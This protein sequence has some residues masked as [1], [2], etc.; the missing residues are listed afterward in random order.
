MF[1]LSSLLTPSKVRLGPEIAAVPDTA[2]AALPCSAPSPVKGIPAEPPSSVSG[3]TSFMIPQ[4]SVLGARPDRAGRLRTG[5]ETSNATALVIFGAGALK[6]CLAEA[7]V[8]K[9][10]SV[11]TRVTDRNLICASSKTRLAKLDRCG[12]RAERNRVQKT[13]GSRKLVKRQSSWPGES[14][15]RFSAASGKLSG[16]VPEAQPLYY[17]P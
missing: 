17:R 6:G 1:K 10:H 11:S 3:R 15:A 13:A 5:A 9:P 12:E 2:A 16:Y 8:V 4:L 7:K 14:V